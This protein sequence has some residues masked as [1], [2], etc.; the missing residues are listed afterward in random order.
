MNYSIEKFAY[1]TLENNAEI[2]FDEG[3]KKID[4]EF[5]TWL[6][7]GYAGVNFN[8]RNIMVDEVFNALNTGLTNPLEFAKSCQK[9]FTHVLNIMKG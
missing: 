8:A 5:L 1:A 9:K 2:W 7:E 4:T 6:L 3:N